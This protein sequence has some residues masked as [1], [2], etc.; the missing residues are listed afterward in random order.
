MSANAP[1]SVSYQ[2]VIFSAF[3]IFTGG[4]GLW[5]GILA[6][7][8][9]AVLNPSSRHQVGQPV[10]VDIHD[11][12]T[13]IV[14]KLVMYADCPEL[15]SLPLAAVRARILDTGTLRSSADRRS[16]RRSSSSIEILLGMIVAQ[17]MRQKRNLRHAARPRPRVLQPVSSVAWAGSCAR[18]AT[19][20]RR[21]NTSNVATRVDKG[22]YV[23][24]RQTSFMV[25]GSQRTTLSRSTL[26]LL[27]SESPR[28][29]SQN[30]CI[31]HHRPATAHRIEEVVEVVV[32]SSE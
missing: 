12:L 24:L 4:D 11:P 23:S 5:A 30:V 32:T 26:R 6:S 29:G 31:F 21:G 19:Q 25:S 20:K 7:S 9:Q 8:S 13:A 28:R 18:P 16:H 17:A 14:H 3:H 1:P 27:S 15:V 22:F 2:S 10:V